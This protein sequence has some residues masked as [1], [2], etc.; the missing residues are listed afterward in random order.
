MN[1]FQ[2][3]A[4]AGALVA[5]TLAVS[6]AASATV[7]IVQTPTTPYALAPATLPGDFAIIALADKAATKKTAAVNYFYDFTFD[8]LGKYDTLMQMQAS[9]KFGKPAVAFPQPI[10][11]DLFSGTP[12]GAHTLLGDSAGT[13]TAAV[14]DMIL[15]TG[16]Y[17]LEAESVAVNKEL[18]SGAITPSAVPEP[19]IW[20]LMIT[21]F[22]GLGLMARRQRRMGAVAA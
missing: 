10:S 18:I 17:Y 13:P 14:L 20:G 1:L 3:S 19:A 21:G 9:M 5:A 11:F 22:G 2:K 7:V 16:K 8:L 6:T 12:T 4:V 15:P